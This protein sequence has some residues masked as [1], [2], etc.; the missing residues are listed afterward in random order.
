MISILEFK[1]VQAIVAYRPFS[2]KRIWILYFEPWD[3]YSSLEFIKLLP[4]FAG[5]FLPSIVW[6]SLWSEWRRRKKFCPPP[7]YSNISIDPEWSKAYDV[8]RQIYINVQ[9][10]TYFCVLEDS[11][12]FSLH[13]FLQTGVDPSVCYLFLSLP[14]YNVTF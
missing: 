5:T 10:N 4:R 11:L 7:P 1:A 8:D 2:Q 9:Q 14:L 6:K 13:F 12:S 3:V